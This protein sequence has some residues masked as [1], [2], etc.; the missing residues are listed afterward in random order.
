MSDVL[1]QYATRVPLSTWYRYRL[2]AEQVRTAL[3]LLTQTPCANSCA[4]LAL[5]CEPAHVRAFSRDGEKALFEGQRYALVR[6]RNRNEGSAFRQKKP[7][8]RA[9]WAAETLWSRVR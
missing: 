5:R 9:D 3:L 7:P 4:A 1:P 6:E 2:L 8:M